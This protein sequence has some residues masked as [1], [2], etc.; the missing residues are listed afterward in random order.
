MNK[1]IVFIVLISILSGSVGFMIG[2]R[3]IRIQYIIKKSP[4]NK[5]TPFENY[6]NEEVRDGINWSYQY[7]CNP[8][9]LEQDCPVAFMAWRDYES[10]VENANY[11]YWI[12]SYAFGI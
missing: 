2:D 1:L 6:T 11:N 3:H 10:R 7:V 8:D 4:N 5:L 9:K 12:I